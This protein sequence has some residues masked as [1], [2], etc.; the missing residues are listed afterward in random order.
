MTSIG[1]L[2]GLSNA[3]V[4]LTDL[5]PR[6]KESR[7][8]ISWPAKNYEDF[9]RL[10]SRVE[11]RMALL[12]LVGAEYEED[13]T[14]ELQQI[15]KDNP[16]IS[17]QT[18]KML[19][20]LQTT[21]DD[22]DKNDE[23]LGM[24][25][26]SLETFRQELLE[27]FRKHEEKYKSM[28]NG[29]YSGFKGKP[30]LFHTVIPKGLIAMIASPVKPNGVLEHEYAY[31]HLLYTTPS[32]NSKFVNPKDI[33]SILRKHKAEIRM[34]P[35]G[36]D[37]GDKDILD[38]Y[39]KMLKEWLKFMGGSEKGEAGEAAKSAIKGIMQGQ[40]LKT[41]KLP[42]RKLSEDYFKPE[43]FDLICWFAVS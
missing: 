16:L 31:K 6:I 39:V 12:P 4:V 3:W 42:E 19:D 11:V 13:L 10:K 30:D 40:P 35:D 27:E 37:K 1:I 21:W 33:L 5:H 43:N 22:I 18:Q 41:D 2:S 34:L 14:E 36:V 32:G 29:I 17:K 8:I 23:T 28:P 20:Q 15:V 25:D 26:L 24:D 7:D 9:L 38:N